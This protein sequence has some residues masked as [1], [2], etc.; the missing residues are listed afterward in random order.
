MDRDGLPQWLSSKDCLLWKSCKRHRFDPWVGKIPCRRERQ[1]TPVFLAGKTHGQRNLMGYSPYKRSQRVGHDWVTELN[2]TEHNHIYLRMYSNMKWQIS[3]MQN[4]N[5]FC[6]NLI[7][8][9]SPLKE[10]AKLSHFLSSRRTNL[11]KEPSCLSSVVLEPGSPSFY[12]AFTKFTF[13][14]GI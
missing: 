1:S 7:Q 2:W 10:L 6:T 13:W 12:T 8:G 4:C 5:Y 9:F 14:G 11:E 3:T